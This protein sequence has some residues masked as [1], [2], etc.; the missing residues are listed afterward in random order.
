MTER[1]P[2]HLFTKE[3]K[4]THTLLFPNM[5]PL[6]FQLVQ[7]VLKGSG[8]KV[9]LLHNEGARLIE[10][11]LR[12]VHNDTCYP[13]LITIGQMIDALKSGGY[14]LEHVA[15]IMTQTGGGCR[16]SNYIYL[17]RKALKDAGM[18]QVPVISVSLGKM[19]NHPGF[20]LTFPMLRRLLAALAYGDALMLL[21]NQTRPYEKEKGQTDQLVDDWVQ[22]I[23]ELF[24]NNTG[25]SLNQ[26]R[27]NYSKIV[28]DFSRIPLKKTP[29]VK[30]GIVGEIFVKYSPLANNHLQD[31]LEQEACEVMVPGIMQFMLYAIDM[32]MEDVRLYGGSKFAKQASMLIYTY[33]SKFEAALIDAVKTKSDFTAPASYSALK[34][35]ARPL[36]GVGC[37]MGEGWLL[38]AEMVE[39]VESGYEN[40]VCTQPF[41]CL[42]NHIAGKGMIS[43]IRNAYPKANIVAIDYDPGATKVNQENRIKLMLAIGKENIFGNL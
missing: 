25:F 12:Y 35:K 3:M 37:K 11:G 43:S 10:E 38:T 13:A 40:I 28:C 20:K 7:N 41:G 5:L 32:P 14:D 23:S 34:E 21:S 19:E 42:P 6:H 22:T 36:I 16:A 4:E 30:V 8:Y 31:F 18:E 29:K 9:E 27:Q 24:Q 26:V 33:L 15:L 17:L 39:L 1:V 2:L